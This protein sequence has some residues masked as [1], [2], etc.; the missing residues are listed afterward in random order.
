MKIR[1]FIEESDA[2]YE[3]AVAVWNAYWP[4]YLETVAEWKSWHATRNKE[5]FQQRLLGELDGQVI[6]YAEWGEPTHADY[7]GKYNWEFF[8]H[9]DHDFETNARQI[10][11][12]IMAGLNERNPTKFS[13]FTR[14]DKVDYINFISERGYKLAQTEPCSLLDV[15]TFDTAPFQG[16][17][18]KVADTGIK[19]YAAAEL[20]ASDPKW[21]EK[22]Y[23]L[24]WEISQDVPSTDPVKKT[25]FE[26]Y[27]AKLDDPVVTPLDT[28][29]VA[30][31]TT[32]A[33]DN[34][35][36][37]YTALSNLS[38]NKVN[39]T[40]GHTGLTGVARA[41]RRKGIATAIKVYALARAKADG[42]EVIDTGND[43][44]NPM[45]DLN[46]RL[47]FKPGPAWVDYELVIA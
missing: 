2:D 28:R 14:T 31:D 16:I 39:P 8:V 34:D 30:V 45:L 25:P 24:T 27:S 46:I 19:M 21:K 40:R 38:Y 15:T 29:Y 26:V 4:D 43:E 23:E 37:T 18:D 22:L 12:H 6:C 33:S 44:N 7:P 42:I 41:Y 35:L 17:V 3:A 5:L 32:T 1:E 13:T 36:G 9:P 47:G 10:F 20:K 11:D